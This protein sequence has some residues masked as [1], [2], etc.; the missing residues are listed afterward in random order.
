MFAPRVAT[1]QTRGDT[2]STGR[3]GQ[4]TLRQ[5]RDERDGDHEREIVRENRTDPSAPRRI[6]WD[7]GKIPLF[8]P[9][10]ASRSQAPPP[11]VIQRKLAIGQTDDP[12]E[13]EADRVADQVMR[14]PAPVSGL[15]SAPPQVSQKCAACEEE[16]RVGGGPLRRQQAVPSAIHDHREAPPIVHEALRAPGMP[17]PT[18]ALAD[19][20]QRFGHDFRRVRI[21]SGSR[22]EASA[23]AVGALAYTAGHDIVFSDGHYQPETDNGRRLLAHE[24]THV[25]QQSEGDGGKCQ[26]Q[27]Q[28]APATTSP[29]AD[30]DFPQPHLTLQFPFGFA[31]FQAPVGGS[32]GVSNIFRAGSSTNTPFDTIYQPNLAAVLNWSLHSGDTGVEIGFGLLQA[33]GLFGGAGKGLQLAG[34]IQPAWVFLTWGSHGQHQLEAYLQISPADAISNSRSIAGTSESVSGGLQYAWTLHETE[35]SQ[36]QF[37]AGVSGGGQHTDLANP[38]SG[39][40]NPQDAGFIGVTIGFSFNKVLKRYPPEAS[41]AARPQQ[42]QQ[43]EAPRRPAQQQD[44]PPR[45]PQT[46]SPQPE[47]PQTGTPPPSGAASAPSVPASQEIFFLKDRSGIGDRSP[48]AFLGDGGAAAVRQLQET[49]K[50][51]PALRVQLIGTASVE[52]DAA[53]NLDLGHRRAQWVASQ[54]PAAQLFDPPADDLRPD[55]ARYGTGIVSCGASGAN[56]KIDPHD[57]RVLARFFVP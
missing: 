46:Q 1:T 35:G 13:H 40:P 43:P 50:S 22:A 32:R 41:S 12:L 34:Y 21:H 28:P 44:Q 36:W 30:Q 55:C 24:L 51:N 49:L 33:A 15:S 5:A 3:F 2:R 47:K 9:D 14:M 42:E 17:I 45:T 19:M 38:P 10:Q 26:L 52:G 53:Y 48:G 6:A 29:A 23:R 25:L 11:G 31:T 54:I 57:R 37:F 20:E 56:A 18:H 7:F 8:S 39:T 27:R 16:S 4:R